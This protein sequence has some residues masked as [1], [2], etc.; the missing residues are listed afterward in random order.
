M[1]TN[2]I[3]VNVVNTC[4]TE[5]TRNRFP[6]FRPNFSTVEFRTGGR[7]EAV[8]VLRPRVR[9]FL[10]GKRFEETTYRKRV[11]HAHKVPRV[12]TTVFPFTRITRCHVC[13]RDIDKPQ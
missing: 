10:L 11:I 12:L 1:H 9:F 6:I 7:E 4:L 3:F 8:S 13:M 2:R 5:I